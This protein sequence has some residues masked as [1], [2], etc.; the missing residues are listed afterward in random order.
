MRLVEQSNARVDCDY[1]H[2]CATDGHRSNRVREYAFQGSD[3]RFRC[4]QDI[5]FR[6][7]SQHP[8]RDSKQYFQLISKMVT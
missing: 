8:L 4:M 7:R 1:T 6:R 2:V 3:D 5:Q